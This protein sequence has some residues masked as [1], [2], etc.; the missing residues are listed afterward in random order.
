MRAYI[1]FALWG[2]FV[3]GASAQTYKDSGGTVVPSVAPLVGCSTS[4]NCL[5]PVSSSNPMPVTV[6]GGGGGGG[7]VTGAVGS[8]VDGWNVT[9]GTK[10]DAAWSGSGSATI[11]SVLKAQYGALTAALPA[12]TNTIGAVTQ[13]SG[14]WTVSW[15]GQAVTANQGTAAAASGA[16]PVVVAIGGAA[17]S[18]T[19]PLYVAPASGTVT[20]VLGTGVAGTPATGVVSVQGISGG[21]ALTTSLS[22]NSGTPTQTNVTVGTGS[23]T[24]L[25]ASTAANFIKFCV[26]SSAANG[27]W[28][29]WDG[30]TATAAAPSEYMPPGQCD[31][32]VKS[33]G[34]LPSSQIN[35][36]GSAS[37]ATTLIYN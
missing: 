2:T 21:T 34:F 25:A 20:S 14:P 27:V 9:E 11:V 33:T 8:F 23:T 31:T 22:G 16:W 32:W 26:A 6:T 35:A 13:A 12:G 7:P 3:L 4:G 10:A 17:N 30:G 36:I 37:V 29:R 19:N 15:T 28:V 18:F 1:A 5:G 24:V